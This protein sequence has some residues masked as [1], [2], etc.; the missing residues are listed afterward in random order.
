MR[1]TKLLLTAFL[2]AAMVFGCGK[3]HGG[4]VSQEQVVT[5]PDII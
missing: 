3:D 2:A 1:R 5:E 4:T